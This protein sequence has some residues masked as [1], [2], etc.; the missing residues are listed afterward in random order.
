V[1]GIFG[2]ILGGLGLFGRSNADNNNV[3]I[4]NTL[5]ELK[6]DV[7][8][9]DY[10]YCNSFNGLNIMITGATGTIGSMVLDTILKN[11]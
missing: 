4:D 11:C 2:G 7:Y 10:A 9:D 6:Q 8:L 1:G 5:I 3:K